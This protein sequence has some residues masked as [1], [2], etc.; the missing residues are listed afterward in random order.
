VVTASGLFD[1]KQAP[2]AEDIKEGLSG[3][4]CRCTGYGS[5]LRALGR[6]GGES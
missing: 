5:I 4:L 3:N 2:A 6:L 1:G